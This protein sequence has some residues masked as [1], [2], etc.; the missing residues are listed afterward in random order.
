MRVE[1]A[2]AHNASVFTETNI[3][4]GLHAAILDDPQAREVLGCTGCYWCLQPNRHRACFSHHCVE[5]TRGCTLDPIVH[6]MELVESG[7]SSRGIEVRLAKARLRCLG[8]RWPPKLPPTFSSYLDVHAFKSAAYLVLHNFGLCMLPNVMELTL[9]FIWDALGDAA[10][11]RWLVRGDKWWVANVS[12]WAAVAGRVKNRGFSGVLRRRTPGHPPLVRT[13]SRYDLVHA[14]KG[15]AVLVHETLLSIA[16]EADQEGDANRALL[17]IKAVQV[18]ADVGH[19]LTLT[20]PSESDKVRLH[21]LAKQ[22]M[23]MVRTAF[24]GLKDF[25]RAPNWHKLRHVAEMLEHLGPF[26]SGLNDQHAEQCQKLL[27]LAYECFSSRTSDVLPQLADYFSR[28]EAF[29]HA[30]RWLRLCNADLV[31]SAALGIDSYVGFLLQADPAA[32]SHAM[33]SPSLLPSDGQSWSGFCDPLAIDVSPDSLFAQTHEALPSKPMDRSPP[34]R[35]PLPSSQASTN[36]RPGDDALAAACANGHRRCA[37]LLLLAKVDPSGRGAD[38]APHLVTAARSTCVGSESLVDLLLR[39]G[40]APALTWSRLTAHEWALHLNRQT[41]A[42]MFADHGTGPSPRVGVRPTARVDASTNRLRPPQAKDRLL[43][44]EWLRKDKEGRK[45]ARACPPLAHIEYALR[46]WFS[47]GVED[48]PLYEKAKANEQSIASLPVASLRVQMRRGIMLKPSSE[49]ADF[50]DSGVPLGMNTARLLAL[51]RSVVPQYDASCLVRTAAGSTSLGPDPQFVFVQFD[52]ELRNI[53]GK[54]YDVYVMQLI[55]CIV[56]THPVSQEPVNMAFGRWL[57]DPPETEGLPTLYVDEDEE[58]KTPSW[59]ELKRHL[60]ARARRAKRQ[61]TGAGALSDGSSDE[62]ENEDEENEDSS[63]AVCTFCGSG[64]DARQ[65]LLCDGRGGTCPNSCHTFC[66]EPPL[67]HVP[68]GL[69]LCERCTEH[70]E[71]EAES[72]A[73]EPAEEETVDE[74]AAEEDDDGMEAEEEGNGGDIG[75]HDGEADGKADGEDDGGEVDSEDDGADG[76]EDDGEEGGDRDTGRPDGVGTSNG[77]GGS[78]DDARPQY[79]IN[80]GATLRGFAYAVRTQ[81][82][83]AA[84]EYYKGAYYGVVPLEAVLCRAPLCAPH[85]RDSALTEAWEAALEQVVMAK[86]RSGGRS[87]TRMDLRAT[88]DARSQ[89]VY[90]RHMAG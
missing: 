26:Y 71:A 33:H 62:E 42:S 49:A 82:T 11:D 3:Y 29:R 81:D 28:H 83:G 86:L 65:L 19:H 38:G 41:N 51:H 20:A 55:A 46:V 84:K 36:R 24:R 6:A 60:C 54:P 39:S 69:W 53:D 10:F 32:T 47:G 23:P 88:L 37:E 25:N 27:H 76:D 9:Q 45:V 30:L 4:P 67:H 52:P 90:N 68:Q 31:R 5:R 7:A 79:S 2:F 61:K 77:D 63:S 85:F 12:T 18:L 17:I 35:L 64:A 14:F 74:W 8:I 1:Q 58:D 72:E 59:E 70:T 57:D 43:D 75:S 73:G 40:A 80:G 21:S 56:V 22:L 87:K 78:G 50:G 89:W 34:N 16:H 13:K 48:V 66:C 44:L 15:F